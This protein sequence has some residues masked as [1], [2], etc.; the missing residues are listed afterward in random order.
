[1]SLLC[2]PS[3]VSSRAY[4]L[5]VTSFFTSL[6]PEEAGHGSHKQVWE[7]SDMLYHVSQTC[8]SETHHRWS[9]WGTHCSEQFLS[10]IMYS[11]L[12]VRVVY[13]HMCGHVPACIV[14][15]SRHALS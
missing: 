8:S 15:V 14:R 1:M 12:S 10:K 7:G 9:L 5:C 3:G 6:A 2:G 13:V 11:H 4:P